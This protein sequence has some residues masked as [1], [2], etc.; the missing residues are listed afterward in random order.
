MLFLHFLSLAIFPFAC[1]I[2]YRCG[3][4]LVV[5]EEFFRVNLEQIFNPHGENTVF[6]QKT[7]IHS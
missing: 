5:E 3:D 2:W 1:S 6:A 7:E 4:R